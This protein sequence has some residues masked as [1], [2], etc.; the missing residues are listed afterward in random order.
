MPR[1]DFSSIP[2][3][4][5]FE[6]T[7]MPSREHPHAVIIVGG[8]P[9]GLTLALDLGQRGHDV[10]VAN[11]LDFIPGG[12]K[13]ICFSKRTLDI[14]NRLGIAERMITKGTIWNVGK[15]FRGNRSEP[16]YEFDMLAHKDQQMPGFIN[17]QQYWVEEFLVDALSELPNVQLR[18]GH[19]I[20]AFDP[21]TRH[22]TIE[23]D[24]GSYRAAAD[25][26]AACD[27]SKSPLRT[28]LG[29]E[30]EGRTFE[31]HFLI[32]DVKFREKRPPERWF[33][34]DP[35]WGGASALLHKQPDDVWRLDFQLG[36]NI[37]RET[38]TKPE[39]VEP[40]MVLIAK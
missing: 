27:G 24:E 9:V 40:Y 3:H 8:G 5:C 36:R 14:W 11:Q 28:M 22:L 29:L 13:A 6:P 18:W 2:K 37:D 35:P 10:V 26:I 20:R 15:V 33:W 38:A 23:T 21:E 4:Q 34:F 16:I 39:N 7:R 32:A 30:F 17:L 12:S 31:D 19:Q 25:W 1:D